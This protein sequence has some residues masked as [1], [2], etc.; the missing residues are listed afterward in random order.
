VDPGRTLVNQIVQ[1]QMK[2]MEDL[3]GFGDGQQAFAFQDVVHVRLGNPGEASQPSF[4]QFAAMDSLA[5]VQDQAGLEL[6][7][8]HRPISRRNRVVLPPGSTTGENE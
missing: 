2:A 3:I 1:I 4:T 6:P 7:K 5:Q 8:V